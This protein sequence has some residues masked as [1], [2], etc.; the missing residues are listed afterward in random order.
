MYGQTYTFSQPWIEILRSVIGREKKV[1]EFWSLQKNQIRWEKNL[2]SS[3]TNHFKRIA[4]FLSNYRVFKCFANF[5]LIR[6]NLW[7]A[8][9]AQVSIL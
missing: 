6:Q 2:Y 7:S 4:T 8:F 1:I 5:V 9:A 3:C